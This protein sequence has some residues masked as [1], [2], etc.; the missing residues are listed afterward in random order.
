MADGCGVWAARPWSEGQRDAALPGDVV[1][2][3]VESVAVERVDVVAPFR[4]DAHAPE[5]VLEPRAEVAGELGP[6]TIGAELVD[7][8]GAGSAEHVR[9]EGGRAG[10]GGIAQHQIGVV[11]E[12]V[13]LA[14][15]DET[16]AAQAILSPTAAAA[17]TE[18]A[19]QPQCRVHGCGPAQAPVGRA[20]LVQVRGAGEAAEGAA[21]GHLVDG[22]TKSGS[23]FDRSGPD[24]HLGPERRRD[25]RQGE[26]DG[27]QG[28]PTLQHRVL[29][30]EKGIVGLSP[31]SALYSS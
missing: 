14:A 2:R 20:G 22:G 19:M 28:D 24:A 3:L 11:G 18:V 13:E 8:D 15:T 5:P 30:T 1:L 10:G 9:N 16:G 12:L 17:D 23:C 6:G 26:R 21:Q 7:A 31:L 27:G 29:R 25:E 4:A